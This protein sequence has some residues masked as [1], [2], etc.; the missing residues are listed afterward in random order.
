MVTL[1]V[2]AAGASYIS[3]TPDVTHDLDPVTGDV[4]ASWGRIDIIDD[5]GTLDNSAFISEAYFI[6]KNDE[7][8][9]KLDA[10]PLLFEKFNCHV[11][12]TF[13][14]VPNVLPDTDTIYVIDKIDSTPPDWNWMW[15]AMVF[16]DAF[17]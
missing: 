4:V 13:T 11:P 10:V 9:V 3:F 2:D 1:T 7:Y 6:V 8:E 17:C 14:N 5:P 16:D 15:D 12:K